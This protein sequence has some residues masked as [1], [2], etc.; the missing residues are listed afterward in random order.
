MKQVKLCR[1]EGKVEIIISLYMVLF[2][3]VMLAYSLQMRQYNATKTSTEDALAASNLASAVIDI[4]EFGKSHNIIIADPDYAY[5]IY[6][7]ALK[8]NM[9][10]S[11]DWTSSNKSAISGTV[12]IMDYIVYNVRNN[13]VHIYCYGQNSYETVI[14]DGLGNVAA[15]NGKIIDNT[16]IYS[17][18]TFPVEGIFDIHTIAV[19]DLLVDIPL[20]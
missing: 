18:I 8:N 1:R 19:K 6:K 20:N 10:L 13:D 2:I 14:T 12:E 15:P 9:E 5:D 4:E 11:D 16:S 7:E 17:R 3:V